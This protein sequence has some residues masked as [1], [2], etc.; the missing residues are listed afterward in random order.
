MEIPFLGKTAPL[1][2]V[3]KAAR[4]YISSFIIVFPEKK[5]LRYYRFVRLLC[6]GQVIQHD[7]CADVMRRDS[8]INTQDTQIGENI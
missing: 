7:L 5:V 8:R 3:N 1:A 4:M 6:N 2:L